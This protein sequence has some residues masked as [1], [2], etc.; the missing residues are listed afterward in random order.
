MHCFRLLT[1]LLLII[2]LFFL[3][4]AATGFAVETTKGDYEINLDWV[5]KTDNNSSILVL[6]G[7]VRNGKACKHL[8]VGVLLENPWVEDMLVLLKAEVEDYTPQRWNE[9]RSEQIVDIE[10]RLNDRWVLQDIEIKCEF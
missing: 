3:I 7:N 2:V 10:S 5:D 4:P 6:H 8:V 1:F 9:F